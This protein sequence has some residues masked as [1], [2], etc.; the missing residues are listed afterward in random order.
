M[1]TLT[2]QFSC[3]TIR[4]MTRDACLDQG[5]WRRQGKRRIAHTIG[6]VVSCF[7][8]TQ[9]PA[10]AADEWY[11]SLAPRIRLHGDEQFF[12]MPSALTFINESNLSWAHDSGCADHELATNGNVSSSG[13]ASSSTYRHRQ[14]GGLCIHY[15]E[16]FASN[17]DAAVW[18]AGGPAEDAEGFFMNMHNYCRDGNCSGTGVDGFA[19]NEYIYTRKDNGKWAEYWFHFGNSDTLDVNHEGDWE[20][21]AVRVN[22]SNAPLEVMYFQHLEDVCKL[23]WADVPKYNGKP[24]VWSGRGTHASYPAGADSAWYDAIEEG[25]YL[26][27]G[28]ASNTLRVSDTSW[29]P[30]GGAWGEVG[31]GNKTT[32]PQGPHPSQGPPDFAGVSRCAGF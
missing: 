20:H 27:V 1:S 19:G 13:L 24:I 15:G 6:L 18:D 9:A 7:V 5:G 23:P 3:A 8:A 2:V 11:E 16:E 14:T 21:I 32:G 4:S 30:Y 12:P 25:P 31:T 17:D 29:Y 22:A 28:Q 26:W 10:G